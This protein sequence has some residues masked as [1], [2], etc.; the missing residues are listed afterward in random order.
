MG[1]NGVGSCN[2]TLLSLVR[3][4]GGLLAQLVSGIFTANHGRRDMC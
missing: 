3:A 4:R 2:I 1:G